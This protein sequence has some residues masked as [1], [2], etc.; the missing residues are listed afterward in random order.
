MSEAIDKQIQIRG[1]N[2]ETQ[3]ALLHIKRLPICEVVCVVGNKECSVKAEDLFEC[4]TKLRMEFESQGMLMECK[5]CQINVYPSGMC[6]QM[7]SGMLAYTLNIGRSTSR[8]DI[9]NIFDP[10]DD[11]SAAIT[12]VNEQKEFYEQWLKS[13]RQN[14]R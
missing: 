13:L 8:K 10:I 1:Q 2:G 3:S 7:A 9:V 11:S 5:G 6:R 4:L 14:A 12:T